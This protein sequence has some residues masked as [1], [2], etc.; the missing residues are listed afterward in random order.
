MATY[1]K[2]AYRSR[3]HLRCLGAA[4]LRLESGHMLSARDRLLLAFAN[5]ESYGIAARPSLDSGLEAAHADLRA[6]LAERYPNGLG[7]YVFWLSSNECRFS[8]AGEFIDRAGLPLHCSSPAVIPAVIAGCSGS[9][10]DVDVDPRDQSVAA[11]DATGVG[12]DRL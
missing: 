1:R 4:A 9:G 5:L 11:R 3:P 7:S 8:P 2:P 6:S 12:G 10:I